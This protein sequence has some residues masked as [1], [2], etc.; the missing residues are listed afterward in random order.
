MSWETCL[1]RRLDRPAGDNRAL[2]FLPIA[3][4]RSFFPMCHDQIFPFDRQTLALEEDLLYRISV[5]FEVEVLLGRVDL[6]RTGITTYAGKS[7]PPRNSMVNAL[8]NQ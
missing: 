5:D 2:S 8:T 1:D 3:H 6:I 7:V 4:G